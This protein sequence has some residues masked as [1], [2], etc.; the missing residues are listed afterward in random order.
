MSLPS[1]ESNAD[2]IYRFD[3]D[4]SR[5][6]CSVEISLNVKFLNDLKLNS[7]APQRWSLSDLDE[8]WKAEV[9][10]G[11]LGTPINL[12]LSS[13]KVSK[14][15]GVNVD[16]VTCKTDECIPKKLQIIFNVTRSQ[17]APSKIASNKVIEI[18]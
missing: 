15:L 17:D 9:D 1:D 6:D 18:K 4:A 5:S 13:G 12:K 11:D 7:E 14:K 16:L 2:K 8:E 3:I 10:K